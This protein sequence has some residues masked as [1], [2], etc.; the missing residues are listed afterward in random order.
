MTHAQE[1][2]QKRR[3]A[4]PK[5][6]VEDMVA[7]FL[8][9]TFARISAVLKDGEDRAALVRDAVERELKRREGK[10]RD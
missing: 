5:Q 7:R 10:K 1:T 8:K 6:F 9:G 2:P 3:M 4:R